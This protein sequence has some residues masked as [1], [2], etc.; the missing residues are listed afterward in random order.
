MS[1]EDMITQPDYDA[2]VAADNLAHRHSRAVDRERESARRSECYDKAR[3]ALDRAMIAATSVTDLV[4]VADGYS[5]CGGGG[6]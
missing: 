2:A 6:Y 4:A 5:R 1:T 3:E